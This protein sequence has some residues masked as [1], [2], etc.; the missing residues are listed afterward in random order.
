MAS[1][2]VLLLLLLQSF[3]VDI[4]GDRMERGIRNGEKTSLT[5]GQLY[6]TLKFLEP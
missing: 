4:V 6:S 3:K 5:C 1:D 2:A